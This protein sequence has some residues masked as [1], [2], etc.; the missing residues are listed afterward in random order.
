MTTDSNILARSQDRLRR[1]L[2]GPPRWIY[3]SV[4]L[5]TAA[6]FLSAQTPPGAYFVPVMVA[7]MGLL[8]LGVTLLV[9]VIAT[10]ALAG[11]WRP[12]VRAGARWVAVPVV[13]AAVLVTAQAGVPVRVGLALAKSDMLAYA[14]DPAAAEPDRVGP[15][16]VQDAEKL[17]GGTVLFR[18]KGVGFLSNEGWAYS[19]DAD[20]QPQPDGITF[21]WIGG[22][23]YTFVETF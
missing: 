4:L 21:S 22:D 2:V 10:L 23:W 17:P 6:V 18:L 9:R 8:A 20:P 15:Y 1:W 14:L 12:M 16:A 5:V 7:F 3:W 11:G 19:P 13:M